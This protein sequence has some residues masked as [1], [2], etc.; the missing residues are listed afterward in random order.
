MSDEC[1][2][3]DNL[4]PM[5]KQGDGGQTNRVEGFSKTE[6]LAELL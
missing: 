1:A 2:S 4:I 3:V 5:T 6:I